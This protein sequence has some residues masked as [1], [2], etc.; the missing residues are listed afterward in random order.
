MI[1]KDE[2]NI[3]SSTPI[4]I[5]KICRGE[6]TFSKKV[7]LGVLGILPKSNSQVASSQNV[8]LPKG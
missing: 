2:T 8:Q 1:K 5:I 3:K 7:I 4:I 6:K